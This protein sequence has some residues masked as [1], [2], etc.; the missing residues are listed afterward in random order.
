MDI[1][2]ILIVIILLICPLF[3]QNA[4]NAVQPPVPSGT[5][6][7][8][9]ASLQSLHSKLMSG[10]TL[11]VGLGTTGSNSLAPDTETG[12]AVC[13]PSISFTALDAAVALY[14]TNLLLAP[15]TEGGT[16]NYTPNCVWSQAQAD[17]S[18]LTWASSTKF[19]PGEYILVGSTYWQLQTGCWS[20]SSS[21]YDNSCTTGSGSIPSC[22]STAASSCTDGVSNQWSW[23]N[24]GSHGALQDGY[25]GSSYTCGPSA[26]SNCFA[27]NGVT[28]MN[29]NTIPA[30]CTLAE[31]Y[32][33]QP[34]PSELPIRNWME[35][36]ITSVINHYNGGT[37]VGY[38]RVGSPAG[39]E[40][41]PIGVD[42]TIWPYYSTTSHNSRRAQYLSWV[43]K[44][45]AFI[46]SLSPTM[47]I[48]SD[49]NCAG[50]P[51]DCTYADVEASYA[52]SN[53]FTGIGTNGFQV[54][55]VLNILGLG[56]N[57]CV[58][59]PVA[60]S[61]C[62]SGD[63]FYNFYTYPSMKHELQT[64]TAST[65]QDCA[66]GLTGPLAA[67]GSPNCTANNAPN[68]FPGLLPFLVYLQNV[69][70]SG[71]KETVSILELY[72]NPSGSVGS[73]AWTAGDMLLAL[74]PSYSSTGG[75]ASGSQA[76]FV[77][78]KSA[79]ASAFAQYL[80]IMQPPTGLTVTG[81]R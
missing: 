45:D 67:I 80:G 7:T 17:A 20:G 53:S 3:A 77:Q 5:N 30:S 55:D 68:S 47:N 74:S 15:A 35:S 76:A 54:N 57:N 73:P 25:C 24:I 16:N 2:R 44:L 81:V 79:Y 59:P 9:Y 28:V 14:T 8:Y 58:I 65:P 41:S 72:T 51:S 78:Y 40:L 43:L 10:Q 49:L 69:G 21:S 38:I 70:V 1:Q 63:F 61:G 18:Y 36:V 66:A 33:S 31:F 50:N 26:G 4:I 23:I 22:L 48:L 64:L 29:I 60:D 13:T 56:S 46:T 6:S 39:G 11:I 27:A 62:T 71:V 19:I 52:S 32:E 12:T 75:G 42:S 37:S 34:I